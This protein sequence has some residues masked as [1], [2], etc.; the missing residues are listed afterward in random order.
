MKRISKDSPLPLYYQL[1]EI[2]EDMIENNI[3]EPGDPIPTER[4]LS[5]MHSISRMTV[6]KAIMDLVNEGLVYREQGRGT[7]VTDTESKL[8]YQLSK[9]KG[10]TKVMEEKGL[11]TETKILHFELKE[12]T[13]KVK[14][15]LKMEKNQVIEIKR[16]RIVEDEPF[17]I[18]T[19]WIPYDL[20]PDMSQEML[21][22]NSF[23]SLLENKYGYYLDYAKQTIE[24]RILNEYE[25]DLLTVEE[26]AL[27]LLFR[28]TTYL[29]NGRVIEYTKAVY[30]SDKY[31][32]EVILNY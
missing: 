29:K 1:K 14:N 9:L 7:F 12:A 18:E 2:L 20:C 8:K 28:R 15:H 23:Y 25:S 32:H 16:L 26:S 5:E 27:A 21:E 24:P 10:F 19:V 22:N 13:K 3:L 30:R 31:K 11:E 17:A 4:E 6:R